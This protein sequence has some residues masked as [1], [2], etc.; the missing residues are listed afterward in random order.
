M[1]SD[2]LYVVAVGTM[3]NW[4]QRRSADRRWLSKA[5][6]VVYIALGILAA[7]S[8]PRAADTA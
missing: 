3:G 5:G 1:L 7:L 2:G 6:G 8:G 4:L